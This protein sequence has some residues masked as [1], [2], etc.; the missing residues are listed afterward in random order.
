MKSFKLIIMLAVASSTL[1]QSCRK[2]SVWGIRGEG[3]SINETKNLRGFNAISLAIDANVAYTQDS[4]YKVEITGQKNIVA[5]MDVKVE[6]GELKIEFK[7]NVWDHNDLNIVVH[8]PH[9]NQLKITGDGNINVLNT[10]NENNMDLV[11]SGI[12]NISIATASIQSININLSGSGDAKINGGTC[13]NAYFKI[14]GIGTIRSEFMTANYAE[15]NISGVGDIYLNALETLRVNI[16]GSG[17]VKYKGKPSITS[18]I[19]GIGKVI[20]LD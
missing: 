12:G 2:G 10:I 17:D 9:M 7:R 5:V 1:F 11:I 19:S 18:E 20:S 14:S 16:S 8:S 13:K 6:N 4:I 3:S 15:A